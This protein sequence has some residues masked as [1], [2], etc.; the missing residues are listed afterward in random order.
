MKHRSVDLSNFSAEE[1]CEINDK[2]NHWEWDFRLGAAPKN[3][4]QLPRYKKLLPCK[5]EIIASITSEIEERVGRYKLLQWHHIRNRGMTKA[6]SDEWFLE[7]LVNK[8]LL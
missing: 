6:E 4:E 7:R 5:Y 8:K 3:W 2:L 1:L